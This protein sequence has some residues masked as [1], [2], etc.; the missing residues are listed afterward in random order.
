MDA[1]GKPV[2]I[3]RRG[4]IAG[5]GAAALVPGA[6]A[7]GLTCSGFS[8]PPPGGM[9][10]CVAGVPDISVLGAGQACPQWC[11]AACIQS[12]FATSGFLIADQRRIVAALFGRAD[13]CI[14]ATGAQIVATVSRD[15]QADDGRWFRAQA[16]PL[17]DISRGLWNPRVV[18][19]TAWDL[20]NGFPV[21]NGA[22][23]HATLMTRM[24]YLTDHTGALKGIEDI[25]VR[26]PLV[27]L[28]QP[29]MVRSLTMAEAKSVFFVAQVRIWG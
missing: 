8:A 13:L 15:W 23:G 24:T 19:A 26:D 16:Q 7:A 6:A 5:A 3:T 21:I 4:L 14:A 10:R 29:A 2:G 18:Q 27:P 25:T 1:L 17:L 22:L 28:G 9:Q 11:W 20:A 12:L